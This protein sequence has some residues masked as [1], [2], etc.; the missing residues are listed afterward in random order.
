MGS[1]L[2]AFFLL[3][4]ASLVAI[5]ARRLG[6]PYTV[7]LVIAGLGLGVSAP[8]VDF[9]DLDQVHLSPE[10]LFRLFLPVLLFEAAFH[11]SWQKFRENVL[12][13]ALLAVPGVVAA[14]GIGGLFAYLLEPL[15]RTPL[16]LPVALLFV[17]MLAATDPVSVVAMF[18]ELG[19]P[20]R[21]AVLVEGE[22][23]LNDGI[24]VV[25]FIV[26]SALLGLDP[27]VPTVTAEWIGRFLFWEIV[28]GVGAGVLVGLLVS[29]AQTLVD[30]HL[31]EIMLTTIAAFGSYLLASAMHASPVLSVVAAG[32]ACG[33]VGARIGMTPA[34]KVAVVSFWEYAVFAANSFV[35]LLLG[36]EIEL[37]RLLEHSFSIVLAWV[38]LV[39]SR[40]IV[41][42]LVERVLVR[43]SERLPWSWVAVLVWGGLR[44]SLS[45]VLALSLPHDFPHREVLVDLTFG[46]VLLSILVQGTTM[47]PLLR[48]VG[49]LE[50]RS[51]DSES[52]GE[53]HDGE[54]TSG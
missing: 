20:K 35:F 11:L 38:A 1:E 2:L 16:P 28:A 4:V 33:N 44:G 49:V 47:G 52:V 19:V 42:G 51:G 13:I 22:S 12:G 46:V 41:I 54:V 6:V 26:T 32:M 18:K 3:V 50:H 53:A 10:L 8:H 25:A 36:K 45:M 9:L 23:L 24:G 43:T 17:S 37:V 48:R 30:D 21:L 29:Y 15:A 34:N 27:N 5:L 7:A 31:I 39:G 40:A 14:V